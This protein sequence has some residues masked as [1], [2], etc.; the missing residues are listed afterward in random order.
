MSFELTDWRF[1]QHIEMRT[2]LFYINSD[3]LANNHKW[4]L[5]L[6]VHC[7][8]SLLSISIALVVE[9]IFPKQI[10]FF[11]VASNAA[12]WYQNGQKNRL[13]MGQQFL[14][15]G[16]L[17]EGLIC[18]GNGVIVCIHIHTYAQRFGWMILYSACARAQHAHSR[19]TAPPV[20]Y[21]TA[22]TDTV[23]CFAPILPPLLDRQCIDSYYVAHNC[24]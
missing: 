8:L 22:A 5:Y 7:P 9:T 19:R 16:G 4:C 3:Y 11:G 24:Y 1:I 20:T 14:T 23:P 21:A 6:Y 12:W 18:V 2:G 13:E 17:L 15:T 10:D